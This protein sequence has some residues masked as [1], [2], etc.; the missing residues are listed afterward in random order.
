MADTLKQ[1]TLMVPNSIGHSPFEVVYRG[2]NSSDICTA[3]LF[4]GSK[5]QTKYAAALRVCH[6]QAS[7]LESYR[8]CPVSTYALHAPAASLHT[9]EVLVLPAFPASYGIAS[10]G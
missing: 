7:V 4:A 2:Y 1:S 10:A 5:G 8:L 6:D 9:A 3:A